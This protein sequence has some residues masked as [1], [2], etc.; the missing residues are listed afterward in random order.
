V[1]TTHWGMVVGLVLGLVA[2]YG[3]FVDFLVVL[4]FAAVGLIIGR[5]I[6][7]KLDVRALWGRSSERL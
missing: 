2:V 6:D 1:T 4:L 5:V 7:G 3:G